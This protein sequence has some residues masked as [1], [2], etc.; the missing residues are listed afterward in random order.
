[1]IVRDI[2]DLRL[3]QL[4][5]NCAGFQLTYHEPRRPTTLKSLFN[6]SMYQALV[7]NDESSVENSA[8]RPKQT[9]E[10]PPPRVN[11]VE[12]HSGDVEYHGTDSA[13]ATGPLKTEAVEYEHYQH[14]FEEE[15]EEH[16]IIDYTDFT[17][18]SVSRPEVGSCATSSS[19]HNEKLLPEPSELPELNREQNADPQ[20]T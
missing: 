13:S 20:G 14:L 19:V 17:Q 2:D 18:L 9:L 12:E 16:E 11:A 4:G 5:D 15:D 8:P 3:V 7:I 1:W 10:L 6:T